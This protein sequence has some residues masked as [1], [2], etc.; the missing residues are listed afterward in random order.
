MNEDCRLS[1]PRVDIATHVCVCMCAPLM[2]MSD[3]LSPSSPTQHDA[4]L[5]D[6]VVSMG[7]DSWGRRAARVPCWLEL[8]GPEPEEWT[9]GR[10]LPSGR[11]LPR[12]RRPQR[13]RSGSHGQR[14]AAPP[15]QQRPHGRIRSPSGGFAGI[16]EKSAW[17]LPSCEIEPP[18][19]SCARDLM[20]WLLQ[21][22]LAAPGKLESSPHTTQPVPP[23]PCPQTPV[24]SPGRGIVPHVAR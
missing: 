11:F 2:H 13:Q 23:R 18:G 12:P 21:K 6:M 5:P 7:R 15:A 16:G 1:C 14:A 4:Q 3:S 17:L 10:N 9:R 20:V 19:L 24:R 8:S 22:R